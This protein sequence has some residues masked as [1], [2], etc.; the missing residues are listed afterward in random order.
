MSIRKNWRTTL[1]VL[2]ITVTFTSVIGGT[3]AWFT[4]TV[5]SSTNVIEAGTLDAELYSWNPETESWDDA[6]SGTIFN[7]RNWEPGYT[8]VRYVKISNVGT[9][10]FDYSMMIKTDTPAIIEGTHDDNFNATGVKVEEEPYKLADV[11]DVYV[12]GA[13]CA[14]DAEGNPTDTPIPYD[15]FKAIKDSAVSANFKVQN[16]TGTAFNAVNGGQ[17]NAG[18]SVVLCVALHMQETA[19]NE[20]Q[21]L[22]VG[23]GFAL[24]VQA[25]QATVEEDAFGDQYDADAVYAN[26][27][28]AVVYQYTEDEILAIN[29]E[30]NTKLATAYNFCT[31][32]KLYNNMSPEALAALNSNPYK[33]WHADFVVTFDKPLAEGDVTLA[34]QYNFWSE[35]WIPFDLPYAVTE[36]QELRLLGEVAPS[37]GLPVI[38]MNYFELVSGVQEFSCGAWAKNDSVAGTTMTVELRLYETLDKEGSVNEETG[39]YVTIGTFNY[40]FEVPSTNP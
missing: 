25:K 6:S 35:N 29:G 17:L 8:Q 32:E 34:G 21:G 27:P 19:G 14:L 20:Y 2:L 33:L 12:V 40:T 26:L 24:Q 31:T 38:Y 3:M 15:S 37:M 9:L 10:A 11:I 22:S 39:K 36:G 5:E 30:Q 4:D 28:S 23:K 18:D 1:L 13:T 7:Y 16:I